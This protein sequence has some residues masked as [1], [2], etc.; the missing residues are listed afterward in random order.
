MAMERTGYCGVDWVIGGYDPVGRVR[1]CFVFDS[2]AFT[3]A[4][5]DEVD[6]N[7]S[8]GSGGVCNFTFGAWVCCDVISP[9]DIVCIKCVDEHRY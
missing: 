1:D 9:E 5:S 4:V 7:I 3:V 6:V 2:G 8:M